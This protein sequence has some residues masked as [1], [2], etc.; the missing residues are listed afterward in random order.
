MAGTILFT[1]VDRRIRGNRHLLDKL[2]AFN[3]PGRLILGVIPNNEAVS[4]AHHF[5]Q[6][7][8][9]YDLQSHAAR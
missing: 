7:I 1:K 6:R 9:T 5:H 8:F 3:V 4:Y 2:K